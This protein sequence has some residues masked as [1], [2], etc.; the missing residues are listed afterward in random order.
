MFKFRLL[1]KKSQNTSETP[2]NGK[3]L[4][5]LR[6]YKIRVRLVSAFLIISIVPLIIT[7]IISFQL[8]SNA[9]KEKISTYS[10]ELTNQVGLNA[11]IVLKRIESDSVDIA[12]NETT[13]NALYKSRDLTEG[14][15][16]ATQRS[17]NDMLTRRFAMLNDVTD[18]QLITK[19]NLAIIAFGDIN[20]KM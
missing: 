10:M 1:A 6:N 12:F 15:I 13:Q 4:N 5:L 11:S 18:V 2:K 16:L 14:D 8:S 3:S 9:I 20:N 7:A 19:E 17:L